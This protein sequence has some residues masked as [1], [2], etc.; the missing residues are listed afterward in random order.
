MSTDLHTQA[1][2]R[3]GQT[4][5]SSRPALTCSGAC[6]QAVYLQR[7]RATRARL[8]LDADAALRGGDVAAL[9]RVA[10]QAAAMLAA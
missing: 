1:C 9:E 6:R 10:R 3:C 7:A 2:A 5:E 4:F 8:A